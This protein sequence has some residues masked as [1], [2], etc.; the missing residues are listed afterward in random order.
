MYKDK[1]LKYKNK[2][3]NLLNNTKNMKGGK[4]CTSSDEVFKSEISK[5]FKNLLSSVRSFFI[6]PNSSLFRSSRTYFFKGNEIHVSKN[7][8][9]QMLSELEA[10][11]SRDA[12][13]SAKKAMMINIITNFKNLKKCLNKE[14]S[15]EDLLVAVNFADNVNGRKLST[16]M[17]KFKTIED[18]TV[19][20]YEKLLWW[21][22][23]INCHSIGP[24]TLFHGPP[25]PGPGHIPPT[26]VPMSLPRLKEIV[27]K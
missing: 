21:G 13:F 6:M 5:L 11:Y 17:V 12:S 7:I 10:D 9:K 23:N 14:F 2:Y 19:E 20:Y 1:Y 25:I 8:M 22:C 3:L 26:S 4:V 24:S 27:G 15:D 18:V 16:P